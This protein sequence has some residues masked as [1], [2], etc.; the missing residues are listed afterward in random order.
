M[1]DM[2][3]ITG[4]VR[5]G[6]SSFA[7]KWA[8]KKAIETESNLHYIA[9]GVPSDEEMKRRIHRHQLEREQG[10]IPW[11]TWEQPTDIINLAPHFTKKDI[12]LLDCLTTLLNNELYLKGVEHHPFASI[13]KGL[14]ALQA[15]CGV[16]ILV[17]N[18]VLHEPLG[19]NQLVFEYARAIGH[20][21]QEVIKRADKAYLVEAG[22]PICMKGDGA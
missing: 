1:A 13:I 2:I 15:R 14:D 18:E 6:K 17:S 5:S 9:T 20:L 16:L 19:D 12:L 8:V 11:K 4:G 10:V 7:E 3:F 22:L 21:H